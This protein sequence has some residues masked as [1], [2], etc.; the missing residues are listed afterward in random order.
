MFFADGPRELLERAP[1]AP[2]VDTDP[3]LLKRCAEPAIRRKQ[4]SCQV[5]DGA[6]PTHGERS[7]ARLASRERVRE[8]A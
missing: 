4:A 1:G 7:D 8:L 3:L 2:G 6:S 5:H